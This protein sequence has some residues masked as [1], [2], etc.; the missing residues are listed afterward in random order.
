MK[1][2]STNK[3]KDKINEIEYQPSQADWKSFSSAL[4]KAVPFD[5]AGLTTGAKAA[6][7]AATAAATWSSIFIKVFFAAVLGVGIFVVINENFY[8][9]EINSQVEQS[10]NQV[11]EQSN[12]TMEY[13]EEQSVQEHREVKKQNNR[14]DKQINSSTS[15]EENNRISEQP[16][17]LRQHSNVNLII[18][19]EVVAKEKIQ[20]STSKQASRVVPN[21]KDD[22]FN[23][24]NSSA[25]KTEKRDDS[26]VLHAESSLE[27]QNKNILRKEIETKK[28]YADIGINFLPYLPFDTTDKGIE[29][30]LNEY[31]SSLLMNEEAT[32]DLVFSFEN[33]RLQALFLKAPDYNGIT[34][35]IMEPIRGND[36]CDFFV[37]IG[38]TAI[39]Y[40]YIYPWQ[41]HARH[42]EFNTTIEPKLLVNEE[43][44]VS[45]I[46]ETNKYLWKD[47]LSGY[48]NLKP[49]L[50][51]RR[52]GTYFQ[53]NE[54]TKTTHFLA[55]EM[56]DQGRTKEILLS[57]GMGIDFNINHKIDARFGYEY[58]FIETI[59]P[60]K[61]FNN[62]EVRRGHFNIGLNYNF[63][64]KIK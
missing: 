24:T 8:S 21:S 44:S 51:V 41:G 15:I 4:D 3:F 14:F 60:S 18:K 20:T 33:I 57:A 29:N 46:A 34:F 50:V 43:Y 7:G 47:K 10:N 26:N 49:E 58:G 11:L 52:N 53:Y 39:S 37:G 23:F 32:M 62:K 48:I 36:F 59:E 28:T 19:N 6:S 1:R 54:L 40:N 13:S 27:E 31:S 63:R 22:N 42:G 56:A 38:I 2:K 9:T 45:I 17:V 55:Y 35:T 30:L 12:S 61:T 5:A 64:Q 25:I 16:S